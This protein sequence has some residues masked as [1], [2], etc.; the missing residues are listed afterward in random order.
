MIFGE[1]AELLTLLRSK[2]VNFDDAKHPHQHS[3]LVASVDLCDSAVALLLC[4]IK[5]THC[6][7]RGL[8]V[9]IY[10]SGE[11]SLFL[12]TFVP[13]RSP[14]VSTKR[15]TSLPVDPQ[16]CSSNILGPITPALPSL[17]TGYLVINIARSEVLFY[18]P[19][20]SGEQ[21]F[22][23]FVLEITSCHPSAQPEVGRTVDGPFP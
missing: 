7:I 14:T 12:R 9:H 21:A 5:A 22:I 10:L 16:T 19:R 4:S 23:P 18:F 11:G 6:H 13:R 15:C 20:C 17:I 8:I 1:P 3:I 2:T